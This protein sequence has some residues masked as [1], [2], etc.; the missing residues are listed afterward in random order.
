MHINKEIE[1]LEIKLFAK[2]EGETIWDC[3]KKYTTLTQS[4]NE[5]YLRF[6]ESCLRVGCPLSP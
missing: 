4:I 6:K 3:L 2:N 5:H 1:K